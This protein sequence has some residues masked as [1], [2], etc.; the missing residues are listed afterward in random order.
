ML[1]AVLASLIVAVDKDAKVGRSD[2]KALSMTLD[3]YEIWQP[4]TSA[5]DENAPQ[6]SV[7]QLPIWR[8]KTSKS[9]LWLT[10]THL[11]RW[12]SGKTT[13]IELADIVLV[14]DRSCGC[15]S[16]TDS[17]GRH[18]E[19]PTEDW[20]RGKKLKQTL[21]AAS[22]ARGARVRLNVLHLAALPGGLTIKGEHKIEESCT[23]RR[24]PGITPAPVP[25]GAGTGKAHIHAAANHHPG[26]VTL[27]R[28]RGH[29]RA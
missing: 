23:H 28:K 2:A 7:G 20:K 22:V 3:P 10:R 29:H 4:G 9:V 25:L 1:Q 12:K 17:R 11:W 21:L 26:A 24:F 16:M 13:S 5:G 8:H 19:L 14:G 6:N 27:S 18:E 15:I